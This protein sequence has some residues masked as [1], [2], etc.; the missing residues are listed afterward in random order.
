[1]PACLAF[2]RCAGSCKLS[3]T[4]RGV[5]QIARAC[6]AYSCLRLLQDAHTKTLL[7]FFLHRPH[8]HARE[9]N[10]CCLKLQ[11]PADYLLVTPTESGWVYGCSDRDESQV[12]H[13]RLAAALTIRAVVQIL[14]FNTVTCGLSFAFLLAC[15]GSGGAT[16]SRQPLSMLL[17]GCVLCPFCP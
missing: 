4:V 1:M 2:V 15:R 9:H 10:P 17:C 7:C 16:L 5:R 6:A 13:K 3:C 12:G 11:N 14:H 8:Y